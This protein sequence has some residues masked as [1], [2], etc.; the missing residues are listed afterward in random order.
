[1]LIAARNKDKRKDMDWLYAGREGK[2][3]D[4]DKIVNDTV[5]KN[6]EKDF[7]R[8]LNKLTKK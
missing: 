6:L 3:P 4:F 7:T 8:E 1:M 5:N 2:E